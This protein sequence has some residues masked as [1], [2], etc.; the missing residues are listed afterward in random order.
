MKLG[1][2]LVAEISILAIAFAVVLFFVQIIPSLGS[3]KEQSTIGMYKEIEITAGNIT[4]IVGEPVDAQ[5]NYSSYEPAILQLNIEFRTWITEGY[6]SLSCNGREITTIQAT[7]QHPKIAFT[8][9]TFANAE[10]VKPPSVN[11]DFY[12]NV[13]TFFSDY[14]NGYEGTL[15]YEVKLRGSR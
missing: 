14:Q 7:S 5:F 8:I 9:I 3:S 6:L 10:W 15:N 13:I 12:P 11:S 2:L 4:V 1:K